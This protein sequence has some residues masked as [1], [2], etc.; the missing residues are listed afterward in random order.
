MSKAVSAGL[1]MYRGRKAQLEVLLVHPGGPY[2]KNK[3]QDCWTFPRGELLPGEDHL[4]AAVR[5]FAEE[6]GIQSAPPYLGL[7]SVRLKSGKVVHAWA[8]AGTCEPEH[9]RS[10]F[11][12]MEWP[13]RSGR[14]QQFPEID[15]AEFFLLPDALQKIRQA[16]KPLLERL[17]KALAQG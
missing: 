8:F 11:F 9:V 14:F 10:N 3:D 13:P 2:W 1:I 16:E 6:T 4:A 7:N 5:E 17:E 12:E 15:R